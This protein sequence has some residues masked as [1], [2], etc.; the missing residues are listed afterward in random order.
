MGGKKRSFSF[1]KFAVSVAI[2]AISSLRVILEVKIFT[3]TQ[4][5]LALGSLL[6]FSPKNAKNSKLGLV[7]V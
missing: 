2:P 4:H 5:T 6:N 3:D 1:G 7:T